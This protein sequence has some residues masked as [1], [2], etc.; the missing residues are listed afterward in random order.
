MK[1]KIL[2]YLSTNPY[3]LWFVRYFDF[4]IKVDSKKVRR[5]MYSYFY[6]H[7]WDYT[8]T[9]TNV[10]VFESK[11]GISVLIETHKPGVLI[12]KA[13]SFIEGLK[14]WLKHDLNRTDIEINIRESKLWLELY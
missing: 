9:L 12:G 4:K 13:G 2:N 14:E 6:Y 1:N 5:S 3:F 8:L 10:E 7:E 11:S